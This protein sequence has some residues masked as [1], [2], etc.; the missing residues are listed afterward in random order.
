MAVALTV[1]LCAAMAAVAVPTSRRL[2]QMF[3]PPR[4]GP[5]VR[6][7]GSLAVLLLCGLVAY[8]AISDLQGD[9]VHCIGRRCGYYISRMDDQLGFWS[10]TIGWYC[11]LQFLV[12]FAFAGFRT[13]FTSRA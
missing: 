10:A 3:G 11:L 1:L 13:C 6:F 5:A 8:A 2:H 9:I 12:T 4:A 7:I